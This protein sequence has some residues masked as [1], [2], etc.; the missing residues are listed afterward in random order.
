MSTILSSRIIKEISKKKK[1]YLFL[2]PSF[3][4]IILFTYYPVISAFYHSFFSWDVGGRI[5]FIGLGN[6]QKIIFHDK[7]FT[8]SF[9][10]LG[11]LMIAQVLITFTMPLLGAELIFNLKNKEIRFIYR[12]IFVI[13]LVVPLMVTF[14]IWKFI[15]E[16]NFG[17]LNTLLTFLDLRNLTQLWLSDPRIALY[18]IIGVGF[19]WVGAIALLIYYAG[20]INIPQGIFDEAK[21][22]GAN[23]ITRIVKIDIPLIAGQVKLMIILT[24]IGVIQN[25]Q[26]ILVLTRGGPGNVTMVPGLWMYYNAF[27]YYRMGYACAIGT[28]LFLISLSLTIVNIK[29]IK[30]TVEY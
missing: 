16:P 1:L 10:T 7:S 11:K 23:T 20:L 2:V 12:V 24:I 6:F 14:L 29:Y 8:A 25:Y 17:V 4:M 28:V 27:N 13:P 3:T 18:C 15:Y 26:L 30:T 19:P 5:E 22:D 9:L 21:I